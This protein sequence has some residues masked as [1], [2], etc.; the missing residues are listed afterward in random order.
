MQRVLA[1]AGVASRRGAEQLIAE[2]RVRV[3]GR[4]IQEQGVKVDPALDVVE[5]DGRRVELEP[6]AYILF[7]KPRLVV[8]TMRDPAGRPAVHDYMREV[9]S[10]VV[11][12]G[13]LDFQT[14]GVML[15]TND[16]DLARALLH[17]SSLVLKEYRL[18]VKGSVDE[19]GLERFRQSIPIGDTWTRPAEVTRAQASPE[20]TS[21]IVTL[22][23]G[24]NRQ[25]R[26]LAEHAGYEVI[27]LERQ[28][29]AGLSARGLRPGQWRHLT[30]AEL[31]ALRALAPAVRPG[32]R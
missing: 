3:G 8:S 11:P 1:R 25:V 32:D 5:V 6:L 28:R 18:E 22:H 31:K 21:L 10:R 14:S 2:G 20:K 29:F 12:V 17:P 19:R 26:R 30:A 27:R 23:E 7:H 15:L 16:G 9:G 24:K 13:R 4:V